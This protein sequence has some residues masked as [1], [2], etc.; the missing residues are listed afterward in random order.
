MYVESFKTTIVI[1]GTNMY[2]QR[3]ELKGGVEVVVATFNQFIDHLQQRNNFNSRVLYVVLDEVD[4]KSNMG[5]E[6]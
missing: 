4:Q 6:P 1:G 2:D 3:L 5:F